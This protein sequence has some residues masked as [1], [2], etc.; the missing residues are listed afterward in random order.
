MNPSN[1]S[2]S[3]RPLP[4]DRAAKSSKTARGG[5]WNKLTL[6]EVNDK[7]Y[8]KDGFQPG[9][10]MMVRILQCSTD[11]LNDVRRELFPILHHT[12]DILNA[13]QQRSRL[14]EVQPGDWGIYLSE[15]EEYLMTK[16]PFFRDGV[17]NNPGAPWKV[18]AWLA[19]ELVKLEVDVVLHHP[20][21]GT[22]DVRPSKLGNHNNPDLGGVD[23][24]RAVPGS[25]RKKRAIAFGNASI[26]IR[27]RP[28]ADIG[29]GLDGSAASVSQRWIMVSKL[30]A[31]KGS[32]AT[33]ED[34]TLPMLKAEVKKTFSIAADQ[35]IEIGHM[36]QV[37][38]EDDGDT[39][40]DWFTIASDA[41]LR[42]VLQQRFDRDR[43]GQTLDLEMRLDAHVDH[44]RVD[45]TQDDFDGG[46]SPKD[47][48]QFFGL[49]GRCFLICASLWNVNER[50]NSLWSFGT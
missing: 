28:T 19:W 37:R 13:Q 33:I 38:D 25:P 22:P 42:R 31:H 35:E 44:A 20:T 27:A 47:L 1:V 4:P 36:D 43:S 11:E 32:G 2:P 30:S 14:Y 7:Y 46:A 48:L 34:I 41:E 26:R 50:C 8:R 17:A 15:P 40:E 23:V 12:C 21:W 5:G 49:F 39:I 24:E 6:E 45:T 9:Y 3:K 16:V 18:R 10:K 29:G